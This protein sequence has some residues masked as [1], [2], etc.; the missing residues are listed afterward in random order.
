M[1][2][3]LEVAGEEGDILRCDSAHF[4]VWMVYRVAWVLCWYGLAEV[5]LSM[6]VCD[7]LIR[8]IFQAIRL[9]FI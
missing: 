2:G 4:D 8:F 3:D 5:S 9:G 6:E 7:V 1:G